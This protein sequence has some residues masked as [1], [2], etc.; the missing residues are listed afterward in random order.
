M[1]GNKPPGKKARM[2]IGRLQF[3]CNA[4]PTSIKSIVKSINGNIN[5]NE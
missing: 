3:K 4:S 5:I 1:H 2:E